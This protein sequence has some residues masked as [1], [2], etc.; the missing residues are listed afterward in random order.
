LNEN[1]SKIYLLSQKG[2]PKKKYPSLRAVQTA[3]KLQTVSNLPAAGIA[4]N[5]QALPS[6]LSFDLYH[7]NQLHSFN[8]VKTGILNFG[9][10]DF[11]GI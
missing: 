2:K 9:H 10:C 6:I 7:L 8:C 1:R 3:K 5:L 11:F 4:S